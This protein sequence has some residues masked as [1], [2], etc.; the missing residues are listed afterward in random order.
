MEAPLQAAIETAQDLENGIEDGE[1]YRE[2]PFIQ[3]SCSKWVLKEVIERLKKTDLPPLV[4]IE[5]FQEEMI[6]FSK[7][8]EH[9]QH[10]FWA[11]KCALDDLI[12]TLIST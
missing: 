1:F 12:S 10:Y 5:N 7:L 3:V 8:N 9:T 6:Q 11:A 2:M 4:V